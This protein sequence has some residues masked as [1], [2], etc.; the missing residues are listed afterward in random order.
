MKM[1]LVRFTYIS[2]TK[3]ISPILAQSIY[4]STN[5]NSPNGLGTEKINQFSVRL[6]VIINYRLFGELS[7]SLTIILQIERAC[8][9]LEPEVEMTATRISY[10]LTAYCRVTA[11]DSGSGCEVCSIAI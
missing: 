4:Y 7:T 1:K 5:Y 3:S 9:C 11:R 10:R 6:P 2:N 8:G